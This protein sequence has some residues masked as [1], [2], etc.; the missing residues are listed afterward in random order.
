MQGRLETELHQKKNTEDILKTLPEY[1]SNFYYNI[2][3]V[4]SP[5]TCLN[6]IRHIR[7]FLNYAGTDLDKI[8]DSVVARFFSEI[9]YRKDKNGNMIKSSEALSK[10]MWTV[11]NQFF[12][13][14]YKRG[15]IKMNPVK[16]IK[17]PRK[18]DHVERIF[19]SMKDLNKILDSVYKMGEPLADRDYAILY[20]FMNTGMRKTAL[21]E[22]NLNS[23]DFD[24]HTISVIDKRD[25][26]QVYEM[27]SEMEK[28]LNRWLAKRKSIINDKTENLDALFISPHRRRL[29]GVDIYRVV[30]KYSEEA[31][32][33]SISPHKLRAAFVSNFY[34]ASGYDI[35]ATRQAVGHA[36]ISTTSIYIT[37]ANNPRRDAVHF[38]EK[39]LR[40]TE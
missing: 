34:K 24:A 38:M 39:N 27:T 11:L 31:L 28:V 32:G 8:D 10:V 35:E 2:N 25:K 9:K 26:L 6:Y 37:R 21:S 15:D 14:L 13:Y 36:S 1:V 29:N 12:E 5:L 22:M 20:L 30:A 16:L 18:A 4:N 23:L 3:V 40:K 7:T 17:R 19:L 33:K